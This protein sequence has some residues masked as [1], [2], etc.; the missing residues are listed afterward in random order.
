[1][2]L[3]PVDLLLDQLVAD[4]GKWPP[5]REVSVRRLVTEWRA[6]LENDRATLRHI[7]DWPNQR[8]YKIDPLPGLIADAWADHLFGDD[9]SIEPAK[10]DDAGALDLLLEGNGD[11]VG[12]LH[13]AERVVV[14]EGEAWWRVYADRDVADTPLLEWHNRDEVIPLLIGRRILAAAL[15]TEL[16]R[17]GGVRGRGRATVYRHLEIHADGAVEHVLFRGTRTRIGET[18]PLE[19]HAELEDLAAALP[20]TGSAPRRWAHGL[21]M[22][23][24]RVTNGRGLHRRLGLGLSDFDRISDILLDLN[25]AATIGAENAR[26]TAKRRV[27]VPEGSLSGR[28][29]ELRD[30][31]D[32][33]MVPGPAAGFDA[34]EDVL[35]ASNLDAELGR[36][37][38]GPFKV[39]EYSFDASAL[40]THKRDLVETSLTRVGLTPQ[41]VGVVSDEGAGLALSGT[42]LRLRLIPTTKAGRG[43]A[44]PWDDALPHVLSL[45]ARLD[46]L[47]E[48]DGGFGRAW[49]DP[50]TPPSVERANP[51]PRDEVE[52]ATVESTLVGAGVR[53]V[54]ASVESQHPDWTDDQVDEEVD[55]IREDRP[56]SAGAF[57]PGL[58]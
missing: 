20:G 40:I 29:T 43:K 42:A 49:T 45:M 26:L 39:L 53:S 21:P 14:G 10:P 19:D 50:A 56:A 5:P 17:A 36:G 38:D 6:F 11:L 33:I 47:R 23:M 35:V 4:G 30:R 22:L 32:G 52:E 12:D 58:A 28:G 25:E 8:A 57:N 1:M 9:P 15:V 27:V 37:Q 3:D 51:L 2:A 13:A 16:D 31:G 24:G 18:V 54:R 44:R 41:Y 55:R 34:G 46:A 7:A 48:T